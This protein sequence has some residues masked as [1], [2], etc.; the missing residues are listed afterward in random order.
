MAKEGTP[1]AERVSLWDCFA[2]VP[3]PRDESGKRH[4]LRAVLTLV[5]VA[6]L[7]GCRSLYAAAQFGRDRGAGFARELGFTRERPP[8]SPCGSTL[9][10]STLYYLFAALDRGAFEAAVR[11]W[12][13]GRCASA[14]WEAVHVDG[15]ALRGTQGHELPGVRVLA[16]YAHE[17]GVVLDQLPVG[18]GT[19]EHKAA[20]GLLDLIPLR[21]KVVTGDAM[22]CQRDLSRK[23]SK[24][25]ATGSGR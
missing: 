23:V 11:R 15:K 8:H 1:A 13:R 5:A 19:N 25:G 4:P 14:G 7:A 20:L 17:A 9:H 21:G 18:A 12:A 24:K 6:M 10:Y 3:D 16:A 2:D 22:F